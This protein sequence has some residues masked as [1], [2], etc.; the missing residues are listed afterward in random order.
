MWID[1]TSVVTCIEVGNWLL[2]PV[3]SCFVQTGTGISLM[4]LLDFQSWHAAC[5][6]IGQTTGL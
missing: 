2:H 5:S 4:G 1:L 3:R 6:K